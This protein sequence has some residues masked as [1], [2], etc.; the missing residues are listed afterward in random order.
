MESGRR[1][2]IRRG[3][4]VRVMLGPWSLWAGEMQEPNYEDGTY[5]AQGLSRVG[6]QFLALGSSG[7]AT[8]SVRFAVN[9]AILRGWRVTRHASVPDMTLTETGG[10]DPLNKVAA[11]LD[12]ASDEEG[13]RWFVNAAAEL[14]FEADPATPTYYLRPGVVR[15]SPTDGEYASDVYVRYLST[16]G[17]FATATASDPE[18]AARY[19]RVE[20]PFDATSLGRIAPARASRIATNVLGKARGRLGWAAGVEVSSNDLTTVGG[21]PADLRL[22]RA[23]HMVRVHGL[24]DDARVLSGQTYLDVVLGQ[25]SREAGAGVA[26]LEPVGTEPETFGATLEKSLRGVA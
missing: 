24:F 26:S 25:V 5:T 2:D 18:A 13:Q 9:Q 23:G 12:L 15:L 8:S 21:K 14:R 16:D 1:F 3:D 6:E 19:G 22:V 10:T 4:P 17:D 11:L 7:S 20:Y